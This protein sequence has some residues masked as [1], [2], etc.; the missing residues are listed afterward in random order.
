MAPAQFS[1]EFV[2]MVDGVDYATTWVEVRAMWGRGQ[3]GTL[4]ALLDVEAS[5]PV[6][7]LGLD[8]DNGG[9]FSTTTCCAGCSSAGDRCS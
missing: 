8:S 3:A 4:A 1:C 6:A 7:L 2:W 5:L 9:S